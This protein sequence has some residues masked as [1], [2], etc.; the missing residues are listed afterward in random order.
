MKET[1]MRLGMCY[2]NRVYEDLERYMKLLDEKN[3]VMDLTNVPDEEIPMRHFAD[4]LI[5][6][7]QGFITAGARTLADVGTGAGFP[8]LP[9]A[10]MFPEMRVTLID[11]QEKR[12]AFLREVKEALKLDNVTVLHIRAEDAGRS[13]ELRGQFDICTARAVAPLNVLAEYLLPMVRKGGSAL[14]WK[15][16]G[17]AAEMEDARYAA[18]VLNAGLEEPVCMPLPEMQHYLV[19]FI[20]TGD[21]P[22]VYPRKNGTP[23][24]APLAPGASPADRKKKG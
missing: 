17:A 11:A 8:G 15:G 19:R 1:L 10:I 13:R 5:V 12:C 3:R 16:P 21:T 14:C 18:A 9:L 4:S 22:D 20:K 6:A 2:E 7:P 23:S 24:K